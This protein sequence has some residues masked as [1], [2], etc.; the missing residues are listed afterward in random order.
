[1][2][3]IILIGCFAGF[4][5][6]CKSAPLQNS[7][8]NN[9]IPFRYYKTFVVVPVTVDGSIKKDFL[10]D[11]GAGINIISKS[12]STQLLSK[13]TGEFRGKRMSGQEISIPMSVV[14]KLSLGDLTN[15][16]I[17]VG[18][19]D[20]D[21]LVPGAHIDGIL[22]LDFFKDA[23]VTIDYDRNVLR[24]ER[25]DE[26]QKIKRTGTVVPVT[27]D[28]QGPSL[29]V[30]M[31]LILPTGKQ[32]LLEVDT[33]SQD[34]ILDEKF[35]KPLGFSKKDQRLRVREGKDETGHLYKRYFTKLTGAVHIPNSLA[36]KMELPD[37][38]FQKIIY[39]GL[40]GHYFLEK[41][42][43]TYDLPNSEMIF[44][45]RSEPKSGVSSGN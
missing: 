27:L 21:D 6:G 18:L 38:M 15:K 26:L 30:F 40:I 17:P 33:G 16:D 13:E 29:D 23:A 7:T 4:L 36:M 39:D 20:L 1:M 24:F 42:L 22:S 37:V 31:P 8:A 34:L 19:F 32:V 9:E 28:R 5:I 25:T 35:M 14:G 3:K 44:R 10:L 12:L 43:V 45:R 11:T 41:F 2:K